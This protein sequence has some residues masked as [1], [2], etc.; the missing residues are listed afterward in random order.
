MKSCVKTELNNFKIGGNRVP[1]ADARTWGLDKGL[2]SFRS[3]YSSCYTNNEIRTQRWTDKSHTSEVLTINSAR[4]I[5]SFPITKGSIVSVRAKSLFLYPSKHL[6][7]QSPLISAYPFWFSSSVDRITGAAE[8]EGCAE[9][10]GKVRK[11]E[12]T[13]EQLQ[14]GGLTRVDDSSSPPKRRKGACSEISSDH[15][16]RKLRWD[17]VEV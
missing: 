1:C 11:N 13:A 12:T 5:N 14:L 3:L 16:Q 7:L 6:T 8:W 2:S 9:S 4:S 10:K 15:W 17:K